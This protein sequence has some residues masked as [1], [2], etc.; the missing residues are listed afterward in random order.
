[1]S[2]EH[3]Y[4]NGRNISDGKFVTESSIFRRI[5]KFLKRKFNK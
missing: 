5:I 4:N 3:E 1:M 2:Q